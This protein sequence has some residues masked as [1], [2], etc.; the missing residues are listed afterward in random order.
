M[1]TSSQINFEAAFMR[2]IEDKLN[3]MNNFLSYIY[4]QNIDL[5]VISQLQIEQNAMLNAKLLE[6]FNKKKNKTF[7]NLHQ[8]L[9]KDDNQQH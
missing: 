9:H 2:Q 5:D 6:R 8:G 7:N 4:D 1:T 3:S